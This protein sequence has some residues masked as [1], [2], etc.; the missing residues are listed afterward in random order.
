MKFSYT[1]SLLYTEGTA[2]GLVLYDWLGVLRALKCVSHQGRAG[3]IP[4]AGSSFPLVRAGGCHMW[5]LRIL[6]AWN[7]G[8]GVWESRR[9]PCRI[10]SSTLTQDRDSKRDHLEVLFNPHLH[11]KQGNLGITGLIVKRTNLCFSPCR[12]SCS[13]TTY[14]KRYKEILI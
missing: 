11:F 7:L 6:P 5:S 10:H 1:R 8:R 13:D 12:S 14:N 4:S 9:Y 3:T 2:S